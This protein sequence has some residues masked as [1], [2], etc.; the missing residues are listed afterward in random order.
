MERAGKIEEIKEIL[1]KLDRMMPSVTFRDIK[2]TTSAKNS[3][4]TIL[5][6]KDYY[7]VGEHL[8]VRLDMYDYLGKR[9]DYGGDFIRA[10]IYSL[11]LKAGASGSIKDFKNG[12]YLV[13]FTL[14]WEGDV[15][16]SILLIHPSEGVS[17]LWAARKKGYE[18]IAFMGKFLIGAFEVTTECGF[19]LNKNAELCEY[20]DERDQEAF[21][22]RKPRNVPCGAFISMWTY[23]RPMSYLTKLEQRLF[24]RYNLGVEIPTMFGDIHVIQCE[25]KQTRAG[26]KCRFETN[27][28]FPSGF[29]WQNE[30]YPLF[31]QLSSFNTSDQIMTCLKG[32]QVYILGDS[33]G[34]QWVEYLTS[35]VPTF[36]YLDCH[37]IGKH[38]NLVAL[39]MDRNAQ[40]RWMKHHHPLVTA[41]EYLVTDH[42]YIAR[43]IDKIAGDKNTTVVIAIGQHFRP[44]PIELFILRAINIRRAIKRL[45]LRSPDTRVIIKGEN[46]RELD[47]DQERFSDFHGYAQYLVA[48]DIFKDL[49]VAFIDAWDMTIAYATDDVHPS[50]PVLKFTI[51]RGPGKT[52]EANPV[53]A[54][55]GKRKPSDKC[56]IGMESP[57]P[58]GYVLDDVWNPAFCSVADFGP[59]DKIQACLKSKIVYL[60]GDSTSF[61]WIN[62]LSKKLTTLKYFEHPSVP[63]FKTHLA[64]DMERN[65]F[66]QWKKHGL[67]LVTHS[68]YSVKDLGY[69][70][71]EINQI[72]GG[73]DTAIII[74]L[75]QHFRPFPMELFVRRL[76]N[77]RSAIDSLLLRS[78]DTKIV[79][80]VENI[81]EMHSDIERFGDFHGYTQYLA[82][83]D[84][85]QGLQVGMIDAWDMT[86]AYNTNNIHPPDH[87]MCNVTSTTRQTATDQQTA[88][89]DGRSRNG[90]LKDAILCQTET[91]RSKKTQEIEEILAKLDH[92]MPNVTFMNI[93]K[94]TSAKNSKATILNHKDSYCVGEHLMVRLDM[95]DY[96]GKRKEY[97]GDFIR[98]RIYSLG[99]K[100]GAS[101]SIKDFRNG[102][103]LVNFTLFWEGDVRAS[104]LLIHP[105]EGV[106]ALWAARKK[107]YEKIAFMGKFLNGA[108]EVSTEC[109]LNLSKN[110][111][112]CEYLDERDQEAFYCLKPKD[113]PC[114]ALIRL[115]SYNKPISYLTMLEQSL[116]QRSN[117]GVEIPLMTGEIHVVQYNQTKA[118]EKCRLETNPPFPSGFVWQ[119][120]WH[121]LFCKLSMFNT[122]EK[123]Q[124]CLKG[125]LVYFMGDSTVRQWMESLKSRVPSEK[126]QKLIAVNT[127][128]NIQIQWKKH[129]H[130]FIGSLEYTVKDHS[131]M[132][133]DIDD[134]AGDK[135]TVLVIALG[136]HFRPFPIE[137][138]IQRAINVR[139]AIRRLLLRSPDTRVIIKGEN[140]R[141][142]DINQERFSDFHGYAQY[143]AAKDVFRD[144][145]VAFL[146]AWDMTVAYDTKDVHPPDSVVWSEINMVLNF[147]C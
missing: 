127:A 43:E 145:E 114:E 13:N 37:G 92:L 58:S 106:S 128:Q 124:M 112:L 99:L 87:F 100:A 141:E 90:P 119:N 38:P 18:K 28:S 29:V 27:P 45:L 95:Y 81:R 107:G 84:I 62:Y 42:N 78:P 32:K 10:R 144:L 40:V 77:V 133:R 7:C 73:H 96:L 130:P 125:K 21:Y 74:A 71:R 34:R 123:I 110:A 4:A 111:E 46:I 31:C 82:T 9:K 6:H 25:S 52:S 118:S 48:K 101:G 146:D 53:V 121:P 85:F 1:A 136:Q 94:T 16:A 17:A 76:V 51:F 93:S 5:N 108:S 55:T 131:Y 49:D 12:T 22:C 137:F 69:V 115:K 97:G 19:N 80:K 102:T 67:P 47:V 14:F 139:Q 64:L 117:I 24:K 142:M 132:A 44:F 147:V 75:G 120:Q 8:M 54:D 50:D 98:A 56:Q 68:F 104:I 88:E 66:I 33:T 134:I 61:Q 63:V 2:T 103:Y 26:E 86:V 126:P 3:K 109:G 143:L 20:L 15:R 11:G 89:L 30:W 105:S 36:K 122:L 39:D 57:V 65:I 138:F 41:S 91:K 23:N 116:F 59:L 79:I 140:I 135:N 60:M 35:T 83:K 72:P 113:V 70:A 129:G